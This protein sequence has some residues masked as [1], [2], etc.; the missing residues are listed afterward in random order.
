MPLRIHDLRRG[1]P[2]LSWGVGWE[3]IPYYCPFARGIHRWPVDSP[4]KETIR[5]SLDFFLHCFGETVEKKRSRCH[6]FRVR[7]FNT[8]GMSHEIFTC[9]WCAWF[10]FGRVMLYNR[11][12]R[13]CESYSSAPGLYSLSGRMSYCKISWSFQASSLCVMII[14]PLWHLTGIS[15][16]LLPR[17]LSNFRAIV[18]V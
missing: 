15:A 1:S 10:C 8:H 4:H 18:K 6:D 9:F 5:R 14:L 16:A 3:R 17:C 12:M 7:L 13:F 11:V 2:Q